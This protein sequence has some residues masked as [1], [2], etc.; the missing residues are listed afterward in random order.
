MYFAQEYRR[1]RSLASEQRTEWGATRARAG[2]Q[3]GDEP[4]LAPYHEQAQERKQE[5]KESFTLTHAKG[6]NPY[7]FEPLIS[8]LGHT[9]FCQDQVLL[10]QHAKDIAHSTEPRETLR[11]FIQ[12]ILS[13]RTRLHDTD[14]EFDE[15]LVIASSNAISILNYGSL[16]GLFHF[17]FHSAAQSDWSG[18]RFPYANL[19]LA[20]IYKCNFDCTDLRHATFYHACITHSSF[21]MADLGNASTF[22]SISFPEWTNNAIRA[23][24][25]SPNNQTLAICVLDPS[26]QI[27]DLQ[28]MACVGILRGHTSA[29]NS[30]EYFPD[31]RTLVSGGTDKTIR[32]WDLDSGVCRNVLTEHSEFIR[33]ITRS[34]DGQYLA[35]ASSDHTIRIWNEH[36]ECCHVLNCVEVMRLAFSYDGQLVAAAGYNGSI[37]IWNVISAELL[38]SFDTGLANLDRIAFS[39]LGECLMGRT[40]DG[41]MFVWDQF[42]G[43]VRAALNTS[44]ERSPADPVGDPTMPKP[45]ESP[46]S[47]DLELSVFALISPLTPLHVPWVGYRVIGAARNLDMILAVVD[48]PASKSTGITLQVC[49][50]H[51]VLYCYRLYNDSRA[52][53]RQP[54]KSINCIAF[55]SDASLAATDEEQPGVRVWDVENGCRLDYPIS[56]KDMVQFIEFF[57]DNRR[58]LCAFG[59]NVLIWDMVT[60][61]CFPVSVEGSPILRIAL[62]PDGQRAA[63]ATG[64]NRIY[65]IATAT[66]ACEI[67]LEPCFDHSTMSF[68]RTGELLALL[69]KFG[70]VRVWSVENRRC[71]MEGNSTCERVYAHKHPS[72]AFSP[73]DQRLA[74]AGPDR[75]VRIWGVNPACLRSTLSG[76]TANVHLVTYSSDGQFLLSGGDDRTLRVWSVASGACLQ[77]LEG[78]GRIEFMSICLSKR[79]LITA[80]RK[81]IKVWSWSFPDSLHSGAPSTSQALAER[82]VVEL[83]RNIG[84]DQASNLT[85]DFDEAI[86]SE[87]FQQ[88]LKHC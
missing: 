24:A 42:S 60:Q 87:S 81:M 68:S 83:V 6:P 35:S 14:P 17:Q 28:T 56:N 78:C 43:Y 71:V 65:I 33:F 44:S 51:F 72:L 31:E 69:G 38:A 82:R 61:E 47:N 67:S 20:T 12:L 39:P 11:S 2:M 55:T 58:L 54:A 16:C 29:I 53:G 52:N 5:I 4:G 15:R 23:I 80:D 27:W 40:L 86:L 32:I 19:N 48:P 3:L 84:L 62:S 75:F 7:D 88:A 50:P 85:A 63:V 59:S 41:Q 21:R 77:V 26:I 73:D 45:L 76:H 49:Q 10:L 79:L 8:S 66:G 46:S 74:T 18:C 37:R 64:D 1:R 57:P 13:T 9:I 36:F 22:I 34:P 70:S 25:F 30:L